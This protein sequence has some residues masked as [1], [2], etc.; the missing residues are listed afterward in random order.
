ME[1]LRNFDVTENTARYSHK[2]MRKCYKCNSSLVDS[3]VHFG[4]RGNLPWPLNWKGACKAAEKADMILCIGSSLKVSLI[5]IYL[6]FFAA[7]D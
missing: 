7:S 1:Y 4:E 3:I 5:L 2:T 6:C